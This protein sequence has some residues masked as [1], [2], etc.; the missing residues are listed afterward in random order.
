MKPAI[1]NLEARTVTRR[2]VLGGALASAVASMVP[3]KLLAEFAVPNL[4]AEMAT[5]DGSNPKE[6]TCMHF[7][8]Y[9]PE[10]P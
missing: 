7:L 4:L 5:P 3:P 1:K 8:G 10:Q 2:T 9:N 6:L